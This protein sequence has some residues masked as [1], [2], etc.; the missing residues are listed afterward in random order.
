[1]KQLKDLIQ[2]IKN[3]AISQGIEEVNYGLEHEINTLA[4]TTFPCLCIQSG[5]PHFYINQTDILK[6]AAYEY[7]NLELIL[8]DSFPMSQIKNEGTAHKF[9]EMH[10]K[11]I[12][13]LQACFNQN[14]ITHYVL[15]P[16]L[17]AK[18]FNT[19]KQKSKQ[20]AETRITICVRIFHGHSLN[21]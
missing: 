5:K 15:M 3:I 13:L 11:L 7:H 20:L 10:L 19:I 8:W 21:I 14:H 6:E 9:S 17:H 18:G 2:H 4:S 16:N 12:Q 1:M